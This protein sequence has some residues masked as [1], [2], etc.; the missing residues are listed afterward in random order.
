MP[1][2]SAPVACVHVAARTD[3]GRKRQRNEDT[4]SIGV[5]G[6]G[7]VL[8][9]DPPDA[10]SHEVSARLR[11]HGFV[12]GVYDGYGGA[13]PDS[14]PSTVAARVVH[15][16][17]CLVPPPPAAALAADLARAM[18]EAARRVWLL[19]E[20][21][22]EIFCGVATTA[23][24]AALVGRRLEVAHVGDSRAYLYRERQ[25]QRITRDH[26][27]FNDMLD[28]GHLHPEDEAKFVHRGV[29][30]GQQFCAHP[31]TWTNVLEPG[32]AGRVGRARNRWALLGSNQ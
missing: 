15:A 27:L 26:S 19:N 10:Q 3:V 11:G 9:P 29:I 21:D 5:I 18:Q 22:P 6:S 32:W 23:V 7:D 31:K 17:L 13:A 4:F 8:A 30:P 14:L 24:V 25:L 20:P 16:E 1:Y 2:R 12:F 28:A